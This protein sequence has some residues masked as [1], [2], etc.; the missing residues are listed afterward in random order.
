MTE[1]NP[2]DRRSRLGRQKTYSYILTIDVTSIANDIL[3][4]IKY[5]YKKSHISTLTFF[6]R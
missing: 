2:T 4:T 5:L 3:Y 6:K 1:H